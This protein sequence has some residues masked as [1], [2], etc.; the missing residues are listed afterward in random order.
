M[1]DLAAIIVLIKEERKRVISPNIVQ[2]LM[3]EDRD[4]FRE[5]FRMDVGNFESSHKDPLSKYLFDRSTFL[6]NSF[7]FEA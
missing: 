7:M 2:E 1:E 6:D 3:I 4:V 5:M